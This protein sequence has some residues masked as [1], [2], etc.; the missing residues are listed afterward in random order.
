MDSDEIVRVLER[1]GVEKVRVYSKNVQCAC[2][3]A[4][5]R[6]GHSSDSDHAD[7]MGISI[8]PGTTSLVNCFACKFK[9]TLST[10]IAELARQSG[11]DFDAVI[12]MARALDA[13]DL[14]SLVDSIPAYDEV[15]QKDD[16]GDV[17]LP[18]ELLDVHEHCGSKYLINRGILT[19]TMKEWEVHVD[20]DFKR[21]MFPV[22]RFDGRL[23]GAVGRTLVN[24]SL[25]YW[26]YWDFVKSRF[27]FGENKIIP[28]TTGV[29][30]EGLL[31]TV[32]VWQSL[33]DSGLLERYSVVGILGSEASSIQIRKA[34]KWFSDLVLFFDN[35]KAGWN[36]AAHFVRDL[37][38]ASMAR[39][40][41]YPKEYAL[42][43]PLG[44][45]RAG[46]DICPL[47]EDADFF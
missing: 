13:E 44:M 29:I 8:S 37:N 19:D 11:E 36:G 2:F 38:G 15:Q 4:E 27:L 33:R 47:I 26:N 25:R 28:G 5:F 10:A 46:V 43:D 22:R 42:G 17:L 34:R 23:V 16:E 35:D 12:E 14:E 31:D 32:G 30:V 3:L 24:H 18:E 6:D 45:I 9:G 39:Q 21:V 20:T 1:I 41:T 7:S 40:V